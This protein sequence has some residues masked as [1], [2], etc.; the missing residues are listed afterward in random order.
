MNKTLYLEKTMRKKKSYMNQTNILNEGF[1]DLMASVFA[2]NSPAA[3]KREYNK[4]KKTIGKDKKKLAKIEKDY[5]KMRQDFDAKFY[6]EFG[7]K[8][9][10]GDTFDDLLAYGEK[11]FGGK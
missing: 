2:P 1:F 10:K 8:L 6:K 5:K 7:V 3:K 9:A 4:L 11:R